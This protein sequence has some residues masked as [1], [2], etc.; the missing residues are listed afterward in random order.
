[1]QESQSFVRA[2]IQGRAGGIRQLVLEHPREFLTVLG[3]SAGGSIIFYVYT[4]YMQKFLANTAGFSKDQ[5]TEISAVIAFQRETSRRP[6]HCDSRG[7][8]LPV[9]TDTIKRLSEPGVQLKP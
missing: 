8:A 2:A 4:T 6:T 5:A 3:F 7:R 1:M 9:P